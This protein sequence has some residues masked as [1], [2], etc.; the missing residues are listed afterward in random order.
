ME[1]LFVYGTLAPG[2]ENH[3]VLKDIIGTWEMATL[4][5]KLF[6]EGWGAELGCPGIIP[7]NEGEKVKGYVLTSKDLSKNWAM[8]DDYEGSGYSRVL[9]EVKLENGNKVK[10]FVYALNHSN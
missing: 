3:S 8:L 4:R 9:V 7:S 2:K 6:N 1:K 10:A 5:G